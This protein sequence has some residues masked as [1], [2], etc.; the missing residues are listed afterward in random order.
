MD[1]TEV[2]GS[3][4]ATVSIG[5]TDTPPLKATY[6]ERYFQPR[7]IHVR[8]EYRPE[9]ADGW[10]VHRWYP[11]DISA[12]GPRILKPAKDGSQR[13]GAEDLRYKTISQ[14]EHPEWL[15]Q[16]VSELAPSGEVVLPAVR[17]DA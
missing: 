11:V 2:T 6:Q 5:V 13:L 8:F 15:R 4:F 16:L 14:R 7:R 10:T 17:H 9:A 3:A 12:H 1:V